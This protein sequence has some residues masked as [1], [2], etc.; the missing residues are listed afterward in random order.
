MCRTYLF[1]IIDESIDRILLDGVNTCSPF[2]FHSNTVEVDGKVANQVV[3]PLELVHAVMVGMV[4]VG[5]I[6]YYIKA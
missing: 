5:S 3:V 1:L 2:T 4:K 6:L